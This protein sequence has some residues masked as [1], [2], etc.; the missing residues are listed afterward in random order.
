MLMHVYPGIWY[1][2]GYDE[3]SVLHFAK[4]LQVQ[5]HQGVLTAIIYILALMCYLAPV[6]VILL[7][8]TIG[9]IWHNI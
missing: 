9:T 1:N 7:Q 6:M 8:T 5:Y 4:Y 3:F 2:N